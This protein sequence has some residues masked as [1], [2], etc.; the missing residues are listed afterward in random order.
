MRQSE[1]LSPMPLMEL[2]WSFTRT[3]ILNTALEL[4]IFTQIDQ[5]NHT[6]H[7]IASS[8]GADE[9]GVRML[10]NALAGLNLVEKHGDRYSLPE[11]SRTFLSQSSPAYMAEFLRHTDL[12]TPA[13]SNLTQV[14]RTGKP[15]RQIEAE[16]DRGD[17][18]SKLVSGLFITNKPGA[19]LAAAA[20]V[21]HRKCVR[22][23]D[24]GA[25]SGVWGI[26]FAKQDPHARVTVVD[27]HQVV[28]VTK[29]F[30]GKHGMEDRFEY[31]AGD[32]REVDFGENK[33]DVAI[34]GHICHS[35]GP[36]RT[37]RLFRR[38]RQALKPDAQLVIAEF[39]ADEDRKQATFP[40][41]FAL[42]MLVN[43]EEGDTFTPM[44]LEQ[45]LQESGFGPVRF[46]DGPMPSPLI[47]ADA[48][49]ARTEEKAA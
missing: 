13:W 15:F 11:M 9:R 7:D 2:A 22:V 36:D 25:G 38:I 43:T 17:F 19:E 48:A 1:P 31:L 16:T 42:N 24:I 8:L 39:L 32:F 4:D 20:V 28:E 35:E 6:A 37:K 14:V 44:E 10:L 47:I 5:G 49:V 3:Q 33:Y 21:G 40:L 34:L 30:V 26:H 18:F 41:I 12:I 27:F 45:W 46:L 23:L 29:T